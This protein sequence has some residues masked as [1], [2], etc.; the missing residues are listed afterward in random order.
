MTT[1]NPIT[2]ESNRAQAPETRKGEHEAFIA[3]WLDQVRRD[4]KLPFSAFHLAYE[5]AIH[6]NRRTREAWPNQE[7]I[8][9]ESNLSKTTIKK[10][11]R[12]L[13]AAG[14]LAFAVGT[15]RGVSSR[16]RAVLKPVERGQHVDPFAEAG[17][18][19]AMASKGVA[20]EPRRGRRVDPDLLID[21]GDASKEEAS[22][23]GR[24]RK[25]ASRCEA[26]GP[27]VGG[28]LDA[29][30]PAEERQESKSKPLPEEEN[31]GGFAELRAL[32]RRPWVDNDDAEAMAAYLEAI[33][34]ADPHDLMRAARTAVEN[35]DAPRF[36]PSL[37]KWLN[38]RGWEKPPPE[39]RISNQRQRER[40][41]H[42]RKPRMSAG[43][44]AVLAMLAAE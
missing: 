42:Q 26:F 30:A 32:W 34:E 22:P 40:G 16:Y 11:I 1:R 35:C 20:S 4:R 3:A 13:Q 43:E 15:H 27:A 5:I 38:G 21:L 37:S 9:A 28:A 14:H 18:G 8:G 44:E 25:D 17:K 2:A 10:L 19:S 31:Q 6:L 41:Q 33:R 12:L 39:K 23:N 29:P 36:L 7:T 24:E